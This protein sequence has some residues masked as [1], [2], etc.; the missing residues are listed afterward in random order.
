MQA[1]AV[2]GDEPREVGRGPQHVPGP[3]GGLMETARRVRNCTLSAFG[4][5]C[6]ID[7]RPERSTHLPARALCC[8]CLVCGCALAGAVSDS[9]EPTAAPG[10]CA[11]GLFGCMCVRQGTKRPVTDG[12]YGLSMALNRVQIP[13][14]IL[15]A[16]SLWEAPFLGCEISH[17]VPTCGELVVNFQ[18]SVYPGNGQ[19]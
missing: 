2:L 14:Y 13:Q 8:R 7:A 6:G 1:H 12:G 17:M 9:R 16:H 19:H 5:T 3:C 11:S 18:K 15:R 10:P 4:T